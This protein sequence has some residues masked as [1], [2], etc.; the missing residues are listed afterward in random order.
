MN[1]TKTRRGQL[2]TIW[3]ETPWDDIAAYIG[4]NAEKFRPAWDQQRAVILKKGY[5]FTWTFCWPALLVSYVW[6]FYRKQWILGGL[7]LV[8]PVLIVIVYPA[9]SGAFGGVGLAMAT[10]AK[11]FY[12]QDI[13]PKIAKIRAAQPDAAIRA[14]SLAASGGTSK[15]A[16]MLSAIFAAASI[17][18]LIFSLAQPA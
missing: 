6:F 17:A 12:L 11:S 10:M 2:Q 9:A 8:L 14:A 18:A 5:G 1:N 4:P 7:L 15:L 13:I 3:A 16:A